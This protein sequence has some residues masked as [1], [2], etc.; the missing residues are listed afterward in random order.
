VLPLFTKLADASVPIF[1]LGRVLL[2]A[3][4]ASLYAV[5]PRWTTIHLVP[6]FDWSVSEPEAKGM[7][8]GYLW[9]PRIN[10][11]LLK[12]FK[13]I[14][15]A[16]AHKFDRLGKHAQRYAELLAVVA[17]ELPDAFGPNELRLA[18]NALPP[19]ALAQSARMIATSIGQAGDN[20][21]AYWENR[22]KVAISKYWPNSADKRSE[23]ES[24]AL[25]DLCIAAGSAFADAFGTV[26]PYLRSTPHVGYVAHQLKGSPIPQQHP[27]EVVKLIE[28]I[29]ATNR[30]YVDA[31]IRE[32]LD[33][34]VA[35]NAAIR[36]LREYR[37]LD[38]YLQAAGR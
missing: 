9:T 13:S 23:H 8:E 4:L 12:P 11:E 15:L 16:T 30:N 3:H 25:A 2:A 28:K 10:A 33:A 17:L 35:A 34:C 32:T 6:R 31:D 5:D 29:F 21:E 24:A 38:G 18:F 37:I 22:A 36:E 20:R 1:R 19:E 7:W 27:V 26:A 14:F